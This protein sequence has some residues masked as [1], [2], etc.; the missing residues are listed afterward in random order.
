MNKIAMVKSKFISFNLISF[1]TWFCLIYLLSRGNS[2]IRE[3]LLHLGSLRFQLIFC[4][5]KKT[6]FK[7]I[8]DEWNDHLVVQGNHV[9]RNMV[10]HLLHAFHKDECSIRRYSI[11]SSFSDC[12]PFFLRICNCTVVSRYS[13]KLNLNVS[14]HWSSQWMN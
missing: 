9:R 8:I 1:N 10:I 12:P 11:L 13:F 2:Y 3:E 7:F 14:F 6:Y 5:L 4:F